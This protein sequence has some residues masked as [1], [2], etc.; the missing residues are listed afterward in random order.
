MEVYNVRNV[1]AALP[2]ILAEVQRIGV[3]RQSRNGPV[4]VFETPV[5]VVYQKPQER[6]LHWLQRDAN[7]FFHFFESL[8]MLSGRNDVEFPA[9]FVKRMAQ[10]SDDGVTFHGAYGYR[11]RREFN[12]DQLVDVINGLLDDPTS[13]RQVIQMWS[14]DRDLGGT[15]V[16]LPCN[17]TITVQLNHKNELDMVVFNRSNDIILGALGANA[18]HFSM[19]QEYLASCVG[20]TM[21]KYWQV[22]ANFHCY[23]DEMWE[24][25]KPII[26][27][28]PDPFRLRK[29]SNPYDHLET[30][31]LFPGRSEP[32]LPTLFAERTMWDSELEKFM[33][34]WKFPNAQRYVTP[35]FQ[36]VARPMLEAYHIYKK[37]QAP[38]RFTHAKHLLE[39]VA[40]MDWR[41]ACQEWVARREL[42]WKAANG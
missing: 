32:L 7:P 20:A 2:L 33:S 42:K 37:A 26:K 18:V 3:N 29:E 4:R 28:E 38:D 19:L 11:W 21:G 30:F 27:A 39:Q 25:C 22:S 14:A 9:Y 13:R 35:F 1:N 6:V 5:T 15:G 24:Q 23:I 36:K 40:A 16:D 12:R 31:P 34:C 17:L 41:L 8:W 10:Y